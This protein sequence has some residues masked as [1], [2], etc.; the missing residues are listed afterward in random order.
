[1]RHGSLVVVLLVA[2]P[3]SLARAQAPDSFSVRLEVG[4]HQVP[5]P[6]FWIVERFIRP[7][8]AEARVDSMSSA[9]LQEGFPVSG[10]ELPAPDSAE[11][12]RRAPSLLRWRHWTDPGVTE[13]SDGT[14]R[15][16]LTAL[17]PTVPVGWPDVDAQMNELRT[18]NARLLESRC[19]T[20]TRVFV[21][22][23][24]RSGLLM[25]VRIDR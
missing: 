12:L 2:L 20:A 23:V 16:A 3:A 18:R 7:G 5:G 14:L 1:M 11:V 19:V 8:G 4:R 6:H 15:V 10:T 24:A 25:W 17:D 22:S 13:P 9:C 21:W